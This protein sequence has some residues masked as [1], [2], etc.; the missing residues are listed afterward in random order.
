VSWAVGAHGQ[1]AS[2]LLGLS[3]G[4]H[5]VPLVLGMLCRHRSPPM[6]PPAAGIAAVPLPP[7]TAAVAARARGQATVGCSLGELLPL[8]T[9]AA[10]ADQ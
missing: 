9:G 5:W 4:H 3:H 10:P 1:V 8:T 6:P 7:A 2:S